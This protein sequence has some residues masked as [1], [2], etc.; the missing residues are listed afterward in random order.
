VRETPEPDQK[1]TRGDRAT[2]RVIVVLGYRE[3]GAD[4]S[5]GIS[6]ICQAAVRR[7][8]SLAQEARPRA[9]IFS[10]WSSNGGPP[11]AA[12]MA[13]AWRGRR[14][15]TLICEPRATNTAENAVRALQV[16]RTLEARSE[17]IVVCASFH[18]PRVR[19]FFHRLYHQHGYTISYRTVPSPLASPRLLLAELSSITRM[20]RDRRRAL[21]LL[22]RVEPRAPSRPRSSAPRR[23]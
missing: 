5:H 17:V 2:H 12:Q 19:F 1:L 8:E 9:V 20:P 6:A 3:I 15:V 23:A 22:T 7:A 10:G 13:A 18:L 16:L 14:D 4:G 11:E 21:R